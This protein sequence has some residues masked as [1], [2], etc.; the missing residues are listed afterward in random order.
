MLSL[1]GLNL[2]KKGK[3]ETLL[4]RNFS[5]VQRY[6]WLGVMTNYEDFIVGI[7]FKNGYRVY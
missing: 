4:L 2:R 3:K 5:T 1:A 6:F 7:S